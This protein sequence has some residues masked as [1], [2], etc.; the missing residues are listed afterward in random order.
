MVWINEDND[1]GQ[2][3]LKWVLSWHNFW[4]YLNIWKS[5]VQYISLVTNVSHNNNSRERSD[6][7]I[8]TLQCFPFQSKQA[9][10][11]IIKDEY[12]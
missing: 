12:A 7:D 2:R 4:H 11:K 6:C 3:T 1:I 5:L 8:F 9:Y 10:Q